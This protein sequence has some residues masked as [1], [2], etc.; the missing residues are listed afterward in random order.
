MTEE[1][2]KIR[3]FGPDSEPNVFDAEA[4]EVEDG[5][6]EILSM[7]KIGTWVEKEKNA[8]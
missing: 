5:V 2:K 4:K 1:K 3:L 7:K 8:V 6:F